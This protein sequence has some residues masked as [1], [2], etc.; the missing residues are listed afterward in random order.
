VAI[1]ALL[2]IEHRRGGGQNPFTAKGA[3]DAKEIE[4][5]EKN[6][7]ES[8]NSCRLTLILFFPAFSFAHF[9]SFAVKILLAR[10]GMPLNAAH[11]RW[12]SQGLTSILGT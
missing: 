12:R 3:K 2:T 8:S 4:I 5:I 11:C 6:H 10:P 7:G 1:H 9:A